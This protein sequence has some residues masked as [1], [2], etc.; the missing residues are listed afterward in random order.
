MSDST[1]RPLRVIVADDHPIFLIGLR[2]VLEQDDLATVVAE[3]CNPDELLQVLARHPCDV[4]VTDFMMPVELQNDGLRL[5]QRIH[6]DF[7]ALPVIVVTALS[8]AGLFQSMLDLNVRGLL[9]KA[10]LAGELPAAIRGV[11]RGEFFVADSV[12][13]VLI[14]ARQYGPDALLPAEKLSPR[15]L[16]V[17]RLLSAGHTV[18][19]IAA[20]LNRSKQTVSAQK[21]AAMRKLG[22]ANDAALFIYLQESGMS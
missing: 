1:D 4:L 13:R 7:P 2:V 18:G 15:E 3:A 11:Q 5:L 19:Q 14:E 10:S 17:L 9:S 6:R 16:E 22:L 8:N 20:Q 12:R 21:V